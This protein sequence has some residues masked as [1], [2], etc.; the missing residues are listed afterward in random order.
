MSVEDTI[1]EV[2]PLRVLL[3]ECIGVLYEAGLIDNLSQPV[4]D[5]INQHGDAIGQYL[6]TKTPRLEPRLTLSEYKI[7]VM[8]MFKVPTSQMP[9][10]E[11][12]VKVAYLMILTEKNP[13]IAQQ[14]RGVLE[15]DAQLEQLLR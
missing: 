4:K 8:Q 9:F 3:F 2:N 5:F 1:P 12:I 13:L 6:V 11:T 10:Y 14:L 7:R 15:V